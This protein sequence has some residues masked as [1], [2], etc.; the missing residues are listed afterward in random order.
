MRPLGLGGP[1]GNAQLVGPLRPMAEGTVK[2]RHWVLYIFRVKISKAGPHARPAHGHQGHGVRRRRQNHLFG[3]LGA[4]RATHRARRLRLMR[5]GSRK[6]VGLAASATT[7]LSPSA[8][9]ARSNPPCGGK[10]ERL[11]MTHSADNGMGH[12]LRAAHSV[13]VDDGLLIRLT[14][15][16]PRGHLDG[17]QEVKVQIPSAPPLIEY[18]TIRSPKHRAHCLCLAEAGCC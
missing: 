2:G 17:M 10:W 13:I 5:P 18:S 14:V 11:W 8:Q 4:K 12:S 16:Q 9:P 7:S 6:P 3:D 1:D 15:P